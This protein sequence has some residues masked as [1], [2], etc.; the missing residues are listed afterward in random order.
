MTIDAATLPHALFGFPGPLRDRLNA[1]ILDGSKTSTTGLVVDYE[2]CGE[3]LPEPGE[4]SALIDSDEMRIAVLETTEV[5]VVR[6]GDVDVRHAIDEGE[7]DT[8]LD[9]WRAGHEAFWHGREFREAIEQPDFTV[10]DDTMAVLQRFRLVE[11]LDQ[12]IPA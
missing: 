10:D 5:R 3:A 7:G 1:A 11:V 2:Y 9:T 12:P 8:G 6:L 4:L